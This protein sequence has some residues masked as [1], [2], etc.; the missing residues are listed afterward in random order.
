MLVMMTITHLPT[1]FSVPLGEPL[2]YVSSA[3]GFVFLSGCMAGLVYTAERCG[4]Y[5]GMRAALQRRAF[6]VYGCQATLLLFLF[7]VVA[8]VGARLGQPAINDL[9]DFYRARP[10]T[11][12]VSGLLLVYSPPMLDILPMYVLF[13]LVSP[14]LLRWAGRR[15]WSGV[16][17]ASFCLWAGA[18]FGLGEALYGLAQTWLAVPYAQTGAFHPLAWQLPW[19]LGLWL[20]SRQSGRAGAL[21]PPRTAVFCAVAVAAA[22]LVWR[23]VAGQIPFAGDPALNLAFDKWQLGP[24]RLL[25]LLALLVLLMRFGAVLKRRLPRLAVLET[26][27]SASLPVYC[28]HV[29]LVLLALA[30]LGPA[31]PDRPMVVDVGMLWGA[32][33]GLYGVARLCAWLRAPR[34][35]RLPARMAHAGQAGA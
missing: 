31:M 10:L 16:L 29:V 20:G 30:F 11:G 13:L 18:Q 12:M 9:I 6:K 25:N 23:H 3:E 34:P 26:L 32:L 2:G 33:V 24:L 17:R 35:S 15:G 22:C 5:Q 19:V 27:G 8:L 28:A 7:T 21:A 14:W 1:V 4:G